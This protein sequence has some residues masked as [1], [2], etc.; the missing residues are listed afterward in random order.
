MNYI[1][2]PRFKSGNIYDF[3][4]CNSVRYPSLKTEVLL[5]EKQDNLQNQL[6]PREKPLLKLQTQAQ[7]EISPCHR[8]VII[9]GHHFPVARVSGHKVAEG[10]AIRLVHL[11]EDIV[12]QQVELKTFEIARLH[13][14]ADSQVIGE[15]GI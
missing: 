11:I 8:V 5:P 15:E 9:L 3:L 14:V 13:F 6:E 2:I 7:Q 12:D 10:V 4:L 1:D